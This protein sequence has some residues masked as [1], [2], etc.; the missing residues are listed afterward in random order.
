MLERTP[1]FVLLVFALGL[2]CLSRGAPGPADVTAQEEGVLFER[3][4]AFAEVDGGRLTLNFARPAKVA[5]P[6]PAVLLLHGGGWSAGAKEQLDG[7]ARFLAGQGYFAATS[8]YRLAPRH[9]WPAQIQDCKAAVRWLRTKGRDHGVDPD[10]IAALGF[11]AGGHLALMLAT[12]DA[13]DGMEAAGAAVDVSSKVQTAI[14]FFGPTDME[15]L[16]ELG[17]PSEL[18]QAVGMAALG[19]LLGPRFRENPACMS[20]VCYLNPGD[21]PVLLFQGTR[22]PLVPAAQAQIFLDR[23]TQQGVAGT[24]VFIAGAGHG[25]RDPDLGDSI[26]IALRWLDRHLRPDRW[27]SRSREILGR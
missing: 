11:S 12:L 18:R 2:A 22:D 16:P 27:H 1:L 13:D 9:H 20:P 19:T 15:R 8:M 14:S 7:L 21:P 10:R 17:P 25:W 3:N 26:E 24:V 5:G 4:V 23:L 6:L